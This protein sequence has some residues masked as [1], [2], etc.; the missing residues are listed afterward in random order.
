MKSG[1]ATF[2][3]LRDVDLVALAKDGHGEAFAELYR[4][5]SDAI[6]AY[7]GRLLGDYDAANDAL[8]ASFMRALDQLATLKRP[9]AFRSWLFQIARNEA[10]AFLRRARRN[11][12][13]D[14]EEIVEDA[15]PLDQLVE[16]ESKQLA[17]TMLAGLKMEYR[18]ILILREYE[19]LSYA[20]IAEITGDSVSSVR[21]RIFK[22]R[23]AMARRYQC[24]FERRTS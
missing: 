6:V 7:C 9:E 2:Q 12:Q 10:F 16:L 17:E 15:T 21:A 14:P 20:E 24:L 22:A 18:E 3:E 4:R 5:H 23:R 8:Q 19:N 11:G 13:A 1:S